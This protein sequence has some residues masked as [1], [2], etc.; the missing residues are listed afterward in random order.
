M[1]KIQLTLL[2]LAL[3]LVALTHPTQAQTTVFTYQGRLTDSQ[4]PNGNGAYIMEFRLF[5]QESGGTAIQTL[6]DLPVTVTSQQR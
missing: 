3:L 2:S 1:N 5:A 4:T 6:T